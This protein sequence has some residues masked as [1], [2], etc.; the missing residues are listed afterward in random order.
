MTFLG[1]K[2]LHQLFLQFKLGLL[3]EEESDET[4]ALGYS[5][6]HWHKYFVVAEKC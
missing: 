2:E 1:D 5:M 6:K 4:D 3:E